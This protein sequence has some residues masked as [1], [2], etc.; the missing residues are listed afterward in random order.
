MC[1]NVELKN[2]FFATF[3]SGAPAGFRRSP[4]P[5]VWECPRCKNENYENRTVGN[6]KFK[7]NDVITECKLRR[8]D[9]EKYNVKLVRGNDNRRAGDWDCWRYDNLNSW[10]VL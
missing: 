10:K 9:F 2:V 5:G 7:R 8:P 3:I 4:E 6:T 1:Y